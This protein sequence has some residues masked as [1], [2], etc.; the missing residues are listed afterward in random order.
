MKTSEEQKTVVDAL[1]NGLEALAAGDLTARIDV[2]FAGEYETLR[3]NFNAAVLKLSQTMSGIVDASHGVRASSG[4]ISSTSSDLATRTERQAVRL[5]ETAAALD[6]ITNT[7]RRTADGAQ[8]ARDA[9]I[10][11]Q[12][13]AEHGGDVVNQ[14]V[15]AMGA[16]EHSA[17]EITKIISVIDEIAFQTNL[18]A[19]NAGIEAAR[20]GETGRGFAVV[21]Q[22]VR[23]LAQRSAEAAM[24]IKTLISA[25][26]QHVERGVKLVAETGK[27]LDSIVRRVRDVNG[28]ILTIAS[29]AKDQAFSLAEVNT[30]MNQM[31]QF[32]QQNA[33]MVEESTAAAMVLLKETSRMANMMSTFQIADDRDR[34]HAA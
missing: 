22:E 27:A 28:V 29:S 5:E 7:V 16:I 34:A 4:E 13:D 10:I 1:A 19:L 11:T 26:G 2:R 12:K 14:A 30:A 15:E 24:E 31:D 17:T 8:Q 20:A 23:A 6:E 21:A 18:L 25:S 32:T 33:A 9:M 3:G